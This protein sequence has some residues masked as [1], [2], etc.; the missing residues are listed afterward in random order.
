MSRVSDP[1]KRRSLLTGFGSADLIKQES[2]EPGSGIDQIRKQ[3][4]ASFDMNESNE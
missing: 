4:A 3:I 2:E 1:E